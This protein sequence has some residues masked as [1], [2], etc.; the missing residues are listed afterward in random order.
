[1]DDD[2]FGGAPRDEDRQA[3]F[4]ERLGATRN[5]TIDDVGGGR[6]RVDPVNRAVA[7]A[8]E[9]VDRAPLVVRR[10]GHVPVGD[11]IG[12]EA[13]EREVAVRGADRGPHRVRARGEPVGLH[14]L[15]VD[16]RRVDDA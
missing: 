16:V 10:P 13:A 6:R 14:V 15:L 3:D 8:Y 4:G 11:A 2:R 12:G 9:D 1:M 5:D 7:R